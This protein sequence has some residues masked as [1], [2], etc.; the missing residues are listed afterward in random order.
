MTHNL[1]SWTIPGLFRYTGVAPLY[2]GLIGA[3]LP[4]STSPKDLVK[5]VHK[6]KICSLVK[7]GEDDLFYGSISNAISYELLEILFEYRNNNL[8]TS[9][10]ILCGR[11]V[12]N[13]LNY[14]LH[15]YHR[16]G[17]VQQSTIPKTC[18][19][20]QVTFFTMMNKYCN[21]VKFGDN[22]KEFVKKCDSFKGRLEYK[23]S[24]EYYLKLKTS[25]QILRVQCK[26]FKDS[27]P[28]CN[29]NSFDITNTND[30]RFNSE[31]QS[32]ARTAFCNLYHLTYSSIFTN[33]MDYECR[34]N[35]AINECCSKNPI[36]N[37]ATDFVM[38]QN[39]KIS[40]LHL[41][42]FFERFGRQFHRQIRSL[43]FT[44]FL[45]DDILRKMTPYICKVNNL[46]FWFD[47]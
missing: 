23:Q 13:E 17:L 44:R 47:Y 27:F 11:T 28:Y 24:S 26:K 38:G 37:I 31:Q 25:L 36:T 14:L 45:T 19:D 20:S 2:A 15:I 21:V 8:D 35:K 42:Y 22:F 39:S 7:P 4:Q 18:H 41:V 16:I 9:S 43:T 10:L 5:F 33:G 34:V 46:S 32:S 29:R 3:C 40:D 6:L 30:N 12:K 1:Y